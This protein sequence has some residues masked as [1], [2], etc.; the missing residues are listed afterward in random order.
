MSIRVIRRTGGSFILLALTACATT[1]PSWVDF[2][3]ARSDLGV[4]AFAAAHGDP[5][6]KLSAGFRGKGDAAAK[7]AGAAVLQCLNQAVKDP[8]GLLIIGPLCATIA[9]AIG[10]V[11]GGSVAAPL[12][13][14]EDVERAIQVQIAARAPQRQLLNYASEYAKASGLN[15]I[16]V[17]PVREPT[18][19][20]TPPMY[21]ALESGQADTVMEMTLTRIDA[22][23]PGEHKLDY[24]FSLTARGRLIRVKDNA[25]LDTFERCAA[26]NL[27]T[28]DEWRGNDGKL[29]NIEIAQATRDLVEGFVDEWLLVY[30]GRSVAPEALYG[31]PSA[32]PVDSTDD[33]ML[34]DYDLHAVPPYALRP[35]YPADEYRRRGEF[36]AIGRRQ[37][38]VPAVGVGPVIASKNLRPT[39]RWEPLPQSFEVFAAKEFRSIGSIQYDLRLYEASHYSFYPG[40]TL[41]RAMGIEDWAAGLLV[42]S[43]ASLTSPEFT[44]N[45]PL[46]PCT[47]YHWTVRARFTLGG[48]TRATEWSTTDPYT[49]SRG[50]IAGSRRAPNCWARPIYFAL[51]TP[52]GDGTKCQ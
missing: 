49:R 33:S 38:F 3:R 40:S 19:L 24:Q 44:P 1:P 29:F 25:V 46:K 11:Y 27:H 14:L 22:S 35:V 2:E 5:D 12:A 10:A 13:T 26:T 41:M 36:Q 32:S 6:V 30:R 16:L 48:E 28:Y 20:E 7:S 34:R 47:R 9:P 45:L 37:G 17:L 51:V 31:R 23:T 21:T 18:T 52:S 15:G 43:W 8:L 39:L 42:D 50:L 4:V